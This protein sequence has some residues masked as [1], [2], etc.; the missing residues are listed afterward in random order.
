ML[1]REEYGY[2]RKVTEDADCRRLPQ[3]GDLE[4]AIAAGN[5]LVALFYRGFELYIKSREDKFDELEETI[6]KS[7][8]SDNET[9]FDKWFEVLNDR[10]HPALLGLKLSELN[11]FDRGVFMVLHRFTYFCRRIVPHISMCRAFCIILPELVPEYKRE[12]L[13]IGRVMSAAFYLETLGKDVIDYILVGEK[14]KYAVFADLTFERCIEYRKSD[15]DAVIV[16]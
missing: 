6:G 9:E 16:L 3:D 11:R 2:L 13:N 4:K 12:I 5:K 10:Y 15:V 1:S 7:L 8:F 14:A